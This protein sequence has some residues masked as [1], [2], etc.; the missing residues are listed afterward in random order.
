MK[1]PHVLLINP[2]IY[3]FAAYDFWIKPLGLLS[4]ASVLEQQGYEISLIDC[5]DRFHPLQT[6]S[7]GKYRSIKRKFGT[8]KFHRIP[9]EKPTF[10]ND[11]PRPFCR[12]GI[13]IEIFE[14][15]LQNIPTPAVIL[16]SSMMTYWYPGVFLAIKLVKKHFPNSPIVLGGIYATLCKEHA[17][18]NSGADYVIAGEGERPALELLEQLTHHITNWDIVPHKWADFPNPTFRFYSQLPSLVVMTSRGCPYNCSFCA[19]HSLNGPYQQRDPKRIVETIRFHHRT[20]HT[21]HIVFYDEA[22][23]VRHDKHFDVMLNLLHAAK[24]PVI[25]HTPNGI[26]A[27]EI[28]S[29]MARLMYK[30]NFRTIRV[31]YETSN[32]QRQKEMLYKVTDDALANSIDYFEQAGF[33][34]KDIDVYVIMGLPEQ[35]LDEVINSMIFVASLGAKV[36]LTSFSPIPGTLDWERSVS[37]HGFPADADPLLTNNTVYPLRTMDRGYTDY[38]QIRQLAKVLNYSLDQNINL[39]GQNTLSRLVWQNIR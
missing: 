4:I 28:T 19:S 13:D 8:G 31:S 24:F 3:D 21:Q 22:L 5:L 29:D 37:R 23:L 38:Q 9:V 18:Q 32:K 6:E 16:V 12:Y 34:R 14:K 27:K 35:P 15:S 39:F 36:R 1:S 26:H 10:F 11:I 7:S 33:Q 2:W 20:R 30:T 25:F 17:R